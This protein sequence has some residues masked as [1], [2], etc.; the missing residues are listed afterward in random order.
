MR[1]CAARPAWRLGSGAADQVADSDR[2]PPGR[3]VSARADALA[4]LVAVGAPLASG[5]TLSAP[6]ALVD[7]LVAPVPG[8][9]EPGRLGRGVTAPPG[10][11]SARV[12]AP[13]L[14]S[15][16]GERAAAGRA[17]G[18]AVTAGVR[19]WHRGFHRAGPGRGQAGW[20]RPRP[21]HWAKS[22]GCGR[23]RHA[24]GHVD[25][26]QLPVALLHRRHM[27]V[28]LKFTLLRANLSCSYPPVVVW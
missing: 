20:S 1:A 19:R 13:D 25:A 22:N 24:K 28:T 15:A 9:R 16:A 27:R 5:L 11:L 4:W 3:A 7:G 10:S 26:A 2:F 17:G 14:P 18:R 6:L 12:G 23:L 8:G 21:T